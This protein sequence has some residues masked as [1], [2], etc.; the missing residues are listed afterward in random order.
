MAQTLVYG[1][2]NGAL[3]GIIALGVAL[4]FGVMRYLNLAH[5]S[6]II[7]GAYA[8]LIL[9]RLGVDP[10]VSIPVVA[11]LLFLAGAILYLVCF[12][13]FVVLP[14]GNKIKNSLLVSFG[15][16]LL[17]DSVATLV[18]TGE[19]RSI[20]PWYSGLTFGL[21]GRIRHSF[22]LLLGMCTL[23]LSGCS[24]GWTRTSTVRDS[25]AVVTAP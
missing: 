17:F 10:F 5:G 24:L 18:W 22:F 7:L 1:L 2:F 9:F 12:S 6:F 4:V 11:A 21:F 20:S 23:A 15:L 3:Y 14:E 8:S 16:M 25:A 13:R 19:E